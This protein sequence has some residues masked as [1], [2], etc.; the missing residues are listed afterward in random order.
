MFTI[1]VTSLRAIRE[2]AQAIICHAPVTTVGLEDYSSK[3][4][5]LGF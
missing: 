4:V 1:N 2:K 3:T 5:G